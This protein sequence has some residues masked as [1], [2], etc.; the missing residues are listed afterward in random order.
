MRRFSE[1]TLSFLAIMPSNTSVN[2]PMTINITIKI[3]CPSVFDI[4]RIPISIAII[5][6]LKMRINGIFFMFRY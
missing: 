5:I 6:R 2:K 1:E 3:A 4:A